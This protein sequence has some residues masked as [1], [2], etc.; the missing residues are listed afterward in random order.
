MNLSLG[1]PVASGVAAFAAFVVACVM[2]RQAAG[3]LPQDF[4]ER[5]RARWLY[6]F[7]QEPFA[8]R[9]DLDRG[10]YYVADYNLGADRDVAALVRSLT[11]ASDSIYIWGF[12]PCIYWL[13]DRRPAS[14]R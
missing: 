12:E 9:E 14:P 10:L 7:R 13:A 3:D 11:S 4:W 2:M 1:W 5:A 6:T 8:T